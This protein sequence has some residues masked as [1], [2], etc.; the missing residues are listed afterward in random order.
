MPSSNNISANRKERTSEILKK[1]RLQKTL[2]KLKRI[3]GRVKR[4][5]NLVPNSTSE[6]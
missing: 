2:K 4:N 3:P 5:R 6:S 1:K